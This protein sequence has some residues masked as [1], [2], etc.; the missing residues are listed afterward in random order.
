MSIKNFLRVGKL[1]PATS[2]VLIRGDH[3]IGKSQ[4]IRQLATS[5]GFDITEDL[6]DRRC[7]QMTEGDMIG[8][9]STDGE[10]TRFNPPDWFK[11]ACKQPKIVFLDEINR[12]TPEVMQAA[13]QIVLDREL[14]GHRL[15]P[16]SRVY[17]AV[18]TAASYNVN[19]MD[20][21]LLDRFWVIDV[22]PNLEDFITWGRSEC[23]HVDPA[24][25][26]VKEKNGGYN[27]AP[28][29]TDFIHD[30][31]RWLDPP[32]N[33]DMREPQ[34]S[35]R[36]WERVGDALA[37][38]NLLDTP[39]DPDF[40][41]ICVGYLG[42]EASQAFV[43]YAKMQDKMVS[44]KDVV[45]NFDKNERRIKRL[46]QENTTGLIDKV[47]EYVKSKK[48]LTERRKQNLVKFVETLPDELKMNIWSKLI[49]DGT[50]NVAL[51]VELHTALAPQIMAIF[52]V[53]MNNPTGAPPKIPLFMN[54][55]DEKVGDSQ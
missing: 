12:A 18:N 2:S 54:K 49:D 42:A 29:V 16:E 11:S 34:V 24:V 52:G 51:T 7:S 20:P 3:G 25:K 46:T 45:D 26:Q 39:E 15:H 21:A 31:E 47:A 48:K 44:A 13:F 40:Y 4:V 9:P 38:N 50:K 27:C 55:S 41:S 28:L 10:T 36:S 23:A 33:V 53:D 8:L 5:L 30:N 1:L 6:I 43:S 37:I 22:H 35:R 32:K 19:E 14:N 17:A